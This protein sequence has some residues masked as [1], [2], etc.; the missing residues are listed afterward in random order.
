MPLEEKFD[1]LKRYLE[2][3]EVHN[4]TQAKSPNEDSKNP[5]KYLLLIYSFIYI[6][7]I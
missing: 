3:T 6:N 1:V 5:C 2:K 4:K 7:H